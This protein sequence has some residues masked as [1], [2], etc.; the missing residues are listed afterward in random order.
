MGLL[1]IIIGFTLLLKY[2][3]FRNSDYEKR[4]GNRFFQTLFNKGNYGEF[5]T[6]EKLKMTYPESEILTNIY[7]PRLN[8]SPT[9]IDLIMIDPTGVYVFESKNY[10]GWI[11]G[12][13]RNK[14]WTQTF[15]TGH[16]NQFY[17]PIWQN[18]THINA[19]KNQF[20][21]LDPDIFKSYIVFGNRCEIKKL[22]IDSPNVQVL[23]SDKVLAAIKKDKEFS[24]RI[25]SYMQIKIIFDTLSEYT[26]VDQKTKDAHIKSINV[27]QKEI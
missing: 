10:G 21:Y 8:N 13:E 5:L 27:R 25:L 18:Q 20:E 22:S 24:G 1:L 26:L 4:S 15:E 12:S 14:Y 19:L 16:K 17:N 9:E 3:K 2:I 23:T 6:Y 11:F 7:V